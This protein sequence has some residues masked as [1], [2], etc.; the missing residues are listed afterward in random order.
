MPGDES[1][2][3]APVLDPI[4]RV[5]EVVFGVLMAMSITGS[6]S[7]AGAGEGEIRTM[8]VAALGCNLAWGLTDAVM[9][10]VGTAVE[11]RRKVGL[12]QRLKATRDE[13]QAHRLIAD[14]LPD[15]L[16]AAAD[17]AALEGL[18]KRLVALPASHAG[19]TA[20]DCA[21]ALGVF[22]LVVLATFPVVIPFMLVEETALGLHLSNLLGVATLFL[23]G[24]ALGRHAGGSP[25]KY[26]LALAATGAALVAIIIALG[27]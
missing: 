9:Y 14:A 22:T 23:G 25:W 13:A 16:A 19:L 6:V 12:L 7:V 18:R 8:L 17:D 5:S 20:S 3:R 1:R 2:R 10:L 11:R 26:G 4:E 15:R 24:L 27:G 21:G